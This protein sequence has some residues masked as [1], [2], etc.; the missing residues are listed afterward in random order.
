M[1]GG[2]IRAFLRDSLP[3]AMHAYLLLAVPFSYGAILTLWGS[4]SS[5]PAATGTAFVKGALV[6]LVVAVLQLAFP[7]IET[8]LFPGVGSFLI[9]AGRDL[10]MPA[11]GGLVLFLVIHRAGARL[12]GPSKMLSVASYLCGVFT[13]IGLLDTLVRA[14]YFT[15][16]ELFLLP[17]LRI[18]LTLMVAL[19]VG[20]IDGETLWFRYV[21]VAAL[22]LVPFIASTAGYLAR[23]N[24]PGGAVGVTAGFAVVA[25]ALM[26]VDRRTHGGARDY[27]T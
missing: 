3:T 24:Y 17:T 25:T 9:L 14:P 12:S 27:A 7:D 22:V 15:V 1:G 8:S 18:S 11:L 5:G 13:V 19:L 2:L 16:Y 23:F 21:Y 6:G 10:V 26:V 4:R 20:L